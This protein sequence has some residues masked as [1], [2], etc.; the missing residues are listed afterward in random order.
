M[1]PINGF[2]AHVVRDNSSRKYC[3]RFDFAHTK[4]K[5]LG[6]WSIDEESTLVRTS[7]PQYCYATLYFRDDCLHR[8]YW[9]VISLFISQVSQMVCGIR[10]RTGASLQRMS[11]SRISGFEMNS[12]KGGSVPKKCSK[13]G[14]S[15]RVIAGL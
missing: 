7:N 9:T 1:L 11:N 14:L 5:G 8:L 10:G 6:V 13:A 12:K 3:C 4:E 2:I 15:P